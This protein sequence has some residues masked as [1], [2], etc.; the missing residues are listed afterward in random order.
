MLSLKKNQAYDIVVYAENGDH[1]VCMQDVLRL[2]ED[3]VKTR[4]KYRRY[5]IIDPFLIGMLCS[6]AFDI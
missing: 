2:E 1:C 3:P 6:I 4:N 5:E